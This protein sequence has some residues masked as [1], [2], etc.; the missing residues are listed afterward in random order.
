MKHS[1]FA[2]ITHGMSLR[3]FCNAPSRYLDIVDTMTI[4]MTSVLAGKPGELSPPL[5]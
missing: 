1:H 5:A 4:V 3:T 2:H